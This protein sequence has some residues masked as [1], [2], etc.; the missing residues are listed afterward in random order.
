MHRDPS[1]CL[2]S[3]SSQLVN[4]AGRVER[5]S[6][7]W[8]KLRGALP[9]VFGAFEQLRVLDLNNCHLGGPLPDLGACRE[10]GRIRLARCRLSGPVP[11]FSGFGALEEIG[12]GSLFFRSN[13][14][15][16]W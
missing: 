11:D 14:R 1:R 12:S 16:G 8:S 9:P 10:L 13:I 4:A 3:D 7:P 6:L 2:G 15:R 5:L